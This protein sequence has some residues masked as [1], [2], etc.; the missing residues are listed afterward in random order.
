MSTLSYLDDLRRNPPP[1]TINRS[2]CSDSDDG[3]R[4]NQRHVHEVQGSVEIAEREEDPHNHRFA[5]V[6]GQ[7]IPIGN[8]DHVHAVSFRTD[9]YEN[10]FHQ[11]EGRT[12]GMIKI[13]DRHVHFL[14]SVTS[15]NDG[16]RHQFRVAT[17]IDNPIGEED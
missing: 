14:K 2:S 8:G 5:T 7:A 11:F 9:F 15:V 12:G 4:G 3:N 16:H 13:G 6:S 10:H 1:L 17:L